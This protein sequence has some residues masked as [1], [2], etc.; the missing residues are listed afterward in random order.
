[1]VA[2][3]LITEQMV[4]LMKKGSVIVD[5]AIDQGGNVETVDK[6]TTHQN[7]TYEKFGVLHCAIPNIPSA[8]PKTASYAYAYAMFPYLKS[9]GE[10]GFIDAIKE[11][12]ELLMG[13]NTFNGE[14]TNEAVAQSL[15]LD[16]T[17]IELLVGFKLK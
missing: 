7:P 16:Y 14:I 10:L 3:K 6:L 8:V 4:K 1:M 12:H 15:N 17:Q 9:L 13:V 5:V 2:P 11:N